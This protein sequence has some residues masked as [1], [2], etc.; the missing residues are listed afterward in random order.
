MAEEEGVTVLLDNVFKWLLMDVSNPLA[1]DRAGGYFSIDG[2]ADNT[3]TVV[4][5][6]VHSAHC[7]G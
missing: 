7:Y 5:V 2:D 6:G 3:S 4:L 1:D